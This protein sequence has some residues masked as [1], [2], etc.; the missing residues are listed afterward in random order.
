MMNNLL[1]NFMKI[2]LTIFVGLVLMIGLF[3]GCVKK[4][5]EMVLEKQE[6]S[7]ENESKQ[8]ETNDGMAGGDSAEA[9]TYSG[10]AKTIKELLGVE[11]GLKCVW[12]VEMAE[13]TEDADVDN[14]DE[15][16]TG[17]SLEGIIYVDDGK[18][19]QEVKINENGRENQV[20][21]IGE[22]DWVYQ[23]STLIAQGTKMRMAQADQIDAIDLDKEYGWNCEIWEAEADFFKV[24]E[25]IKFIEI[26]SI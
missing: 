21:V 20:N 25:N 6:P 15:D 23:W 5:D 8:V 3:S 12:R 24:P 14:T 2:K 10:E 11:D 9:K 19:K 17:G 26:S 7:M 18:F 16:A 1:K 4:S 13:V 22:G